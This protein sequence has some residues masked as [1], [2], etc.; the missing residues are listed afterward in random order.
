MLHF[1]SAVY[2]EALFK[3]K[4]HVPHGQIHIKRKLLSVGVNIIYIDLLYVS[5]SHIV[6]DKKKGEILVEVV[7]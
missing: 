1:F 7:G 4:T 2:L 5:N 3:Q 6:E